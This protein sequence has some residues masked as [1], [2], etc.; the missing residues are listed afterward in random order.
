MANIMKGNANCSNV[1][2][3]KLACKSEVKHIYEKVPV[4][5]IILLLVFYYHKQLTFAVGTTAIFLKLYAD[6]INPELVMD[7]LKP[8]SDL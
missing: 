5:Y 3:L 2:I 6:M 7:L 4:I 1:N 8:V